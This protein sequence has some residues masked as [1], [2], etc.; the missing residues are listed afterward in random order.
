MQACVLTFTVTSGTGPQSVSGKVFDRDGNPFVGKIAFNEYGDCIVN[1]LTYQTGGNNAFI[2]NYGADDGTLG[3][4]TS[5]G[6]IN[7]FNL[8]I[9]SGGAGGRNSMV[10]YQ[11]DIFF[12]GNYQGYG[13][14]SGFFSGGFTFE[15]T[16]NARG[17]GKEFMV[18]VLGGDD[19][20]IDYLQPLID[21]MKS[22]SDH[23]RAIY[24][25]SSGFPM[26]PSAGPVTA[27]GGANIGVGWDCQGS[28]RGASSYYLVSQGGNI[29]GD[30]E[31]MFAGQL[32]TS[33][34]FDTNR[35]IISNWG[36]SD[37]T[38]SGCPSTALFT[39][40]IFCG[41]GIRA[42]AGIATQPLTASVQTINLGIFAKWVAVVSQGVTDANPVQTDIIDCSIG[43][44]DGT[45]QASYWIGETSPGNQPAIY[46]SRFLSD[47][48]I[49]RHGNALA[50]ATT[51]HTLAEFVSLSEDGIL[52]ID[53]TL[54]D[55]VARRFQ[56]FALGEQIAPP[57]SIGALLTQL[58]IDVVY[59]YQAVAPLT[60][61]GGLPWLTPPPTRS[62]RGR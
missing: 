39:S 19:L 57:P 46:G 56:W 41:E 27:A 58:P 53:W 17:N 62:R 48:T 29:R 45:R 33:G 59:P 12:G 20:T 15:R 38:V 42:T 5:L 37:I 24:S 13:Y 22:T 60:R 52:T 6:D 4:S 7:R 18:V 51:F 30:A 23:P 50:V 16:T 2:H 49:V 35:P 36:T 3:F 11:A 1:T 10:D 61:D 28:A 44:T 25:L 34:A 43:W 31:D 21:G 47:N 14:I 8:K 26:Q 54:V 55:G 32:Q 40:F 9:A